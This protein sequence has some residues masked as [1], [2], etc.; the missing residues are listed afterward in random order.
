[1]KKNKDEGVKRMQKENIGSIRSRKKIEVQTNVDTKSFQE[2]CT[3]SR[4]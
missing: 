3:I 1:V 4:P 2:V